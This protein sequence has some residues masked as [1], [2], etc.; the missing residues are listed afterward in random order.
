MQLSCIFFN[1][2]QKIMRKIWLIYSILPFLIACGSQ[3][4]P[5]S[6]EMQEAV[7]LFEASHH[8]YDSLSQVRDEIKQSQLVAQ[9]S[10]SLANWQAWQSEFEQWQ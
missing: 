8:L 5:Q 10:I 1:L 7:R 3:E 2:C 6:Q 4:A 9:D